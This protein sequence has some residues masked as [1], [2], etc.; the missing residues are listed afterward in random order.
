MSPRTRAGDTGVGDAGRK[1]ARAASTRVTSA[2]ARARSARSAAKN[3]IPAGACLPGQR[4]NGHAKP[5]RLQAPARSPRPMP[6][7]PPV[8][9]ATLMPAPPDAPQP[10][11]QRRHGQGRIHRRRGRQDRGIADVQVV[12]LMRLQVRIN[13]R[14]RGVRPHPR[15]AALVAGGLLAEG[16]GQHHRPARPPHRRFQLV[17]QHHMRLPVRPL[18]L[19]HDPPVLQHA[20]G[21]R[22]WADPRT[23]SSDA[24]NGRP[25]RS[26]APSASPTRAARIVPGH[27][28]QHLH[29]AQRLALR[30]ARQIPV[31]ELDGLFIDRGVPPD[32][33]A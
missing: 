5:R 9:S 22:G 24:P 32:G 31:V 18:P 7:C 25:R 8:T 2:G 1:S 28:P 10:Q 14:G 17:R 21:C 20:P 26:P 3:R 11:R 30:A 13:H 23:W 12:Q 33:H 29:V 27:P 4:G 16:L 6:C 15:R 19:Q